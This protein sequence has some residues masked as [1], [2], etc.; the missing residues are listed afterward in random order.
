[1]EGA[2]VS[3]LRSAAS[4]VSGPANA[5]GGIAAM[6]GKQRYHRMEIS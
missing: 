5:A 2:A 6:S 3:A 4:K 1:M